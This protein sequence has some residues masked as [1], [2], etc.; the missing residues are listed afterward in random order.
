MI[1]SAL[2]A[3]CL[4]KVL[5]DFQKQELEEKKFFRW[6]IQGGNMSYQEFWSKMRHGR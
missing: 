2:S 1:D 4:E 6:V 3:G 5:M